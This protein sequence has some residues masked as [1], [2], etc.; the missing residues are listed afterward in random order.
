MKRD[1]RLAE[2]KLEPCR[3]CG[4]WP[5]DL[6]NTIGKARQDVAQEDGSMLVVPDAVVSLCPAHHRLYDSRLLNILSYLTQE[7]VANAVESAGGIQAVRRRLMGE[8]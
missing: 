8:G 2:E 5:V 3:V 1:W 4:T 7:E 6:A